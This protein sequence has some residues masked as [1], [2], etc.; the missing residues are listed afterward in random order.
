M[1]NNISIEAKL[2][3]YIRDECLPRDDTMEL[4]YDRNLFEAGIVD[5]AGLISFIG[6]IEKEFH[7]NIPDEDLLPQNFVSITTIA[8]YIRTHQ[9]VQYDYS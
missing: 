5:S 2:S 9:Q 1:S 3:V 4:E 7:L 8:K 6:Y